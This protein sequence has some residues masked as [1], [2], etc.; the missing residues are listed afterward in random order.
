[1]LDLAFQISGALEE[2]SGLGIIHRDVKPGNILVSKWGVPKLADFGI[3]KEYSDIAD[4]RIQQ[5]LTMGIVGTPTYMSPEQ[6][7]GSRDVDFRT[8]IYSL[9]AT[10]YQMVLG[11]LPFPAST[12]QETVVRVA[13]EAPRPPRVVFPDLSESGRGGHLPHDGQGPGR[14]VLVL[15]GTEGRPRRRAG[16]Q[17]GLRQLQGGATAARVAAARTGRGGAP[18]RETGG[19]GRPAAFFGRWPSPAR[20]PPL[21]SSCS[22]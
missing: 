2:A 18:A 3:A 16:R 1:M 17:A 19:V 10:L 4:E 22:C 7:R 5:S 11:D 12:P 9:G 8:D 6:A 21:E 15:R 13:S 14:S 20:W